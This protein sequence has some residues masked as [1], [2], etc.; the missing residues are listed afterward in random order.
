MWRPSRAA[1]AAYVFLLMG[2]TAAAAVSLDRLLRRRSHAY[3]AFTAVV[4]W[5]TLGGRSL[6]ETASGLAEAVET[7][8]IDEARR[9]ARSLVG[10]ETADLDGPELCRAAVESLADNTADAIVGPLLWCALAGP[11]AAC[12]YRAANTLDAMVGHRNERYERFGWAAA[13][14]DDVL[15][16]PAARLAALLTV[17]AAALPGSGKGA[18]TA[19]RILRRD[20]DRHPSP[21]AG[22]VEAAFAGAL[23][24]RLGGANRYG[25]LIEER[26]RIGQG[27]LPDPEAT[28]RAVRLCAIVSAAACAVSALLSLGIQ[29][30][31]VE[32]GPRAS[33]RTGSGLASFRISRLWEIVR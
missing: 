16:W 27:P 11:A 5:A 17:S 7:G 6:R 4:V 13:R 14:L 3:F 32:R 12:I 28:R 30:L 33:L 22:Q 9:L 10:R 18:A 24:V 23:G 8:R 31:S 20:G 25:D 26:P 1:G 19:L 29:A 15:T 2:A 21:N